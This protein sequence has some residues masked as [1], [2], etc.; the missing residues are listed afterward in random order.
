MEVLYI[1][2]SDTRV[3]LTYIY[4]YIYIHTTKKTP[5]KKMATAVSIGVLKTC[6]R[7]LQKEVREYSNRPYSLN[8]TQFR[9]TL[10]QLVSFA[11]VLHVSACAKAILRHVNT[12]N[13]KRKA[14]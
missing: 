14:Q 11:C 12:K 3:K 13:I 4:I 6:Y 9:F 5:S 2:E 1:V 8:L 7:R 10:I